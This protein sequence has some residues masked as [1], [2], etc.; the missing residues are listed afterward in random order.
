MGIRTKVVLVFLISTLSASF[1]Y[2]NKDVKSALRVQA[3]SNRLYQS[4]KYKEYVNALMPYVNELNDTHHYQFALANYKI[5]NYREAGLQFQNLISKNPNNFIYYHYAG[6]ALAKYSPSL[7]HPQFGKNSPRK[8]AQNT[9]VDYLRTA[10]K[11]K[12]NYKPAHRA[13]AGLFKVTNNDY[14]LY[15]AYLTMV[16]E[17]GLNA[18]L[19]HQVCA[20]TSDQGRVTDAL[21][22]C[23]QAIDKNPKQSS[24]YAYLAVSLQDQ[25]ER[26]A[27]RKLLMKALKKFPK[28]YVLNGTL[29]ESL[30]KDKNYSM[31][32]KY[33]KAALKLNPNSNRLQF[34]L[35]DSL[36]E[37]GQYE[38]SYAPLLK[39]CQLDT[40]NI[41][42]IKVQAAKLKRAGQREPASKYEALIPKCH[43]KK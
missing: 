3:K 38:K 21:Y 31:A 2:A 35:G 32:L 1:S 39:S 42:D 17:F 6:L 23:E 40:R 26:E 28:S 8:N 4:K 30:Y 37:L 24:N 10:I 29:G 9:A 33:L 5:K 11:L 20:V 7:P 19:A 18:D 13:L 36:F 16:K 27:A 34:A 43:N 15:K 22:Y 14:E 12:P 41:R 25:N